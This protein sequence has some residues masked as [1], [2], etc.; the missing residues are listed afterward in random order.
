MQGSSKIKGLHIKLWISFFQLIFIAVG[1]S[2][3]TINPRG[4][5][6]GVCTYSSDQGNEIG[7]IFNLSLDSN[8]EEEI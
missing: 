6:T 7:T 8:R 4:K 3:Q 2:I 1:K 5:K